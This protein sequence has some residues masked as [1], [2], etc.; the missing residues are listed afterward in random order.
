MNFSGALEHP[1]L[2]IDWVVTS[3]YI[4][5]FV[6]RLLGK[7][8]DFHQNTHLSASSMSLLVPEQAIHHLAHQRHK[9]VF[10][11]TSSLK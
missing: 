2:S 9:I 8:L 6:K 7:V 5:A 4:N 11:I 10:R 3:M 1:W